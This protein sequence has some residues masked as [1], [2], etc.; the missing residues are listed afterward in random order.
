MLLIAR[1]RILALPLLCVLASLV[2]SGGLWRACIE[3]LISVS[4]LTS[5]FKRSVGKRT[6]RV[7][8][9]VAFLILAAL[10]VM[11][12]FIKLPISEMLAAFPALENANNTSKQRLFEW[13]ATNVPSGSGIMGDMTTSA[14]IRAA[15]PSMRVVVHPQ[16]ENV[17]IRRR[18]Q[19][20][21]G[22]AACP[23]M[24][25]YNQ[26]L[27]DVYKVDYI[28]QNS[29]RCAAPPNS[30]TSVFDVADKI[31]AFQFQCPRGVD[32]EQRFCFRTL[33]D[34]NHFFDL[35]YANEVFSVLKR[36]DSPAVYEQAA[37]VTGIPGEY[38]SFNWK[39]KI[40]DKSSWRPWVDRC[41]RS[42][43]HCGANIAGL[44]MRMLERHQLTDVAT[45]LHSLAA[46]EFKDPETMEQYALY[47]DFNLHNHAAAERYYQIAASVQPP[48]LTRAVQYALYLQETGRG[49]QDVVDAAGEVVKAMKFLSNSTAE[50]LEEVD[51]ICRGAVLLQ[52]LASDTRHDMTS[53]ARKQFTDAAHAL[54]LR[55]QAINIQNSCVVQHWQLFKGES[56]STAKRIVHFF[57]GDLRAWMDE[58]I[59]MP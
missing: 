29:F 43:P 7:L 28:I 44:G 53:A 9:L 32:R 58:Q 45:F 35:V 48:S 24:A 34:N 26:Q 19:F 13:L 18:V 41:A 6:R 47:L 20:S 39:E 51:N 14:A 49:N 15:L 57:V 10:S 16:Y 5:A 59:P 50:L 4:R 52:L 2:A 8:K 42:D 11:P 54:W 46:E 55:A 3:R 25:F 12:F 40:L 30:T 31:D 1:L 23:P 38:E 21:Y 33:F 27:R 56:L 17:G 37:S 36:V 22:V